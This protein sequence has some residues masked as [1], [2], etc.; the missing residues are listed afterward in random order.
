MD[1]EA[2]FDTGRSTRMLR[3]LLV[4][5]SPLDIELTEGKLLDAGVSFHS[6]RAGTRSEFLAALE[7]GPPDLVITDY[8]LP[9]G[10]GLEF[11]DIVRK[12]YPMV[13]VIII[14]GVLDEATAATC[15][16]AGASDYVLKDHLPRLPIAVLNALEKAR[17]QGEMIRA[18]ESLRQSR[19]NYRLLVE[20]LPVAT[21]SLLLEPAP[22]L[23]FVSSRAEAILGI[24][25]RRWT[26]E[27]GFLWSRIHPG[28]RRE[29]LREL[30]RA[31]VTGRIEDFTFRVL[32][33]EDRF[34]WVR[35]DASSVLNGGGR[36]VFQGILRDIS[37]E[38]E[39]ELERNLLFAAAE[40]SDSLV[41]ITDREGRT[42]YANPAFEA[43][44][45]Y[46]REE[47]RGENPRTL[48][49]GPEREG[50]DRSMW[51]A[52]LAGETWHEEFHDRKKDGTP[53]ITRA[54]LSPVHDSRGRVAHVVGI[55]QDITAEKEMEAQLRQM[56]KMDTVGQL[57]GGIAH[58]MSNILTAVISYASLAKGSLQPGQPEV[59]RDLKEV[60]A[61]ARRGSELIRKLLTFSRQESLRVRALDAEQVML[62]VEGLIR[63]ILPETLKIR[64]QALGSEP[65]CR[66]DEG[67]LE[68]VLVNLATNARDAMSG[69]GELRFRLDTV[70]VKE[71]PADAYHRPDP[72]RF[73][74]IRVRDTGAGMS[75]AVK[76]RLFEPFFTTKAAGKGTGL[77]MAVI[78]GL[79]GQQDGFITVESA[80]GSGT[81]I[82]IHLPAT[83]PDPAHAPV[84]V[85]A[86]L[87]SSWGEGK[88]ILIVE[89]DPSIR[90]T[91]ERILARAGFRVAGLSDG[92]EALAL[93]SREDS[94]TDLVLTDVML[95]GMDGV[96]LFRQVRPNGSGPTFI[97]ST[98]Y[99]VEELGLKG[100]DLRGVPFL[101]K[102]WEPGELLAKVR[103]TLQP[104]PPL[105]IGGGV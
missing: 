30:R 23:R 38:K 83:R 97:F 32:D 28:D 103:R 22:R 11:L 42:T 65:W 34:H 6:S 66:G 63:R 39:T 51:K 57:T 76:K 7:A 58:D 1:L 50:L 29:A 60:E 31:R 19:E 53:F 71:I 56:Q 21:F 25:P 35:V 87:V 61:A 72:G 16:Q 69:S 54:S 17:I 2:A 86:P 73:V 67:A 74:R 48:L 75:E 44:T 105:E 98:G 37:Q 36:P 15:I 47:A 5:D 43:I 55:S 80:P 62:G 13:P 89:D 70:D 92:R 59:A 40:Q 94:D 52:L 46:S 84:E 26:A 10:N 96:E 90:R 93:L 79:V 81:E 18:Q 102:P 64:M 99:P 41:F 45:G 24:P 104:E 77:G 3:I 49:G 91:A 20:H 95:P 88:R 100:E 101:P 68:Q 9:D 4:D 14:T 33:S 27:P 12:R 8:F 78:H 85:D 82:G